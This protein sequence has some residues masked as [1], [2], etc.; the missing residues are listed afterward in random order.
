MNEKAVLNNIHRAWKKR[1]AANN[2]VL[3]ILDK[4]PISVHDR[5]LKYW[6]GV[7]YKW[8]MKLWKLDDQR[9]TYGSKHK[10]SNT[11]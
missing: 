11:N 2:M 8:E 10:G 3:R 9:N 6:A 7:E 4:G 1:C 5:R